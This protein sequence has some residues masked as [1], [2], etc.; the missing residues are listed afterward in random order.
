[1]LKNISKEISFNIPANFLGTVS[2]EEKLLIFRNKSKI[3]DLSIT[4]IS[5]TFNKSISKRIE[6]TSL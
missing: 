4:E 5:E 2:D 3:V 6:L 1:M